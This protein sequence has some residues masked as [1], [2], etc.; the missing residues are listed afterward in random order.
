MKR[1]MKSDWPAIAAAVAARISPGTLH[2]GA[3]M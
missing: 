2:P 1:K 3:M